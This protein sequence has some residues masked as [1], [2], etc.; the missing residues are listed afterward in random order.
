MK[1]I[2]I[3]M[4]IFMVLINSI[5]FTSCWNYREV[6]EFSIVSGVAVD[7]GKNNQYQ[8][9]VE[10]IQISGEKESRITSKTIT[11]EGKTMFDAA[12]NVIAISG[13]KLY[14][15]HTKV[16]ILSKEVASEGV[17]KVIEWY[18]RDSETRE[19]VHLLVSKGESAKEIISELQTTEPIKSLALDEMI[20]NQISLSKAP[21][22]NIM[23]F[24]IETKAVGISVVIP[25]VNLKAI[26]GKMT[27]E[28]MGTAIIKNDKLVGFL[29]GEETKDLIFI[30][31]EI[32]GGILTEEIQEKGLQ[33]VISLEIF[34]SKAKAKPVV[35]GNDVKIDLNIKV[36][37]A[38]DEIQGTK[39]FSDDTA[40]MELEQSTE[41][42]LKQRIEFLIRKMQLEYDAD[43][44]GF[45][46]A[47]QENKPQTW[48]SVSGNWENTFKNLEVNVTTKVHIRNSAVL[49]KTLKEGD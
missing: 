21:I 31:N 39:E 19:D 14:W 17:T 12:R 15:A 20:K 48:N 47:L 10:V 30:R 34:K 28:I 45:G 49:S 41:N 26:D 3:T 42:T 2:K 43:I 18:N 37:V 13:K 1:K 24:N 4:L 38:I 5:L 36:T 32:K 7:K 9:T 16:I 40:I 35:D 33:N 29:N 25:A 11:S 8:M 22:T 44:F 6:E 27:P 46:K 23:K